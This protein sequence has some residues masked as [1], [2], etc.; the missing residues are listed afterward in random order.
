MKPHGQQLRGFIHP[1]YV[2]Y[3]DWGGDTNRKR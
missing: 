3:Q 2:R 1:D